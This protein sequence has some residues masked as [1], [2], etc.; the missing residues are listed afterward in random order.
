MWMWQLDPYRV[1]SEACA[2]GVQLTAE[3]W[4]RHFPDTEPFDL[5][6]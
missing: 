4:D 2:G 5:C 3:E 6:G 1:V